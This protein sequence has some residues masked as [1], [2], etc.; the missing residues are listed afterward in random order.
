MGDSVLYSAREGFAW[1]GA[2]PP[3]RRCCSQKGGR[4]SL[5]GVGGAR[6]PAINSTPLSALLHAQRPRRTTAGNLSDWRDG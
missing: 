2:N 4:C 6:A 5:Q 3:G 1:D